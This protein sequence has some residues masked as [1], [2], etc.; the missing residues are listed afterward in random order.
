MSAGK[1]W[2]V[3]PG[4]VRC[5]RGL[6]RF[7]PPRLVRR[8]VV[9]GVVLGTAVGLAPAPAA[10]GLPSIEKVELGPDRA[11]HLNGQPFFPIMAWLQDAANFAA[12]RDCGMNTTAGYWP[13]SSG[14]KDVVEY[15]GLVAKAGLYGVMPF[16]AGLK[17]HPQLLGYIHDDEPDLP[18]QVS[19]ADVLPVSPLALNRSTPLWK[20]VDGVTHSWSVLDPLEKAT[21]AI[22]LR[23]P[24]T[25]ERLAVWLTISPGLAVAKELVFEGDGKPL[26]TAVLDA[27]KG[28]QEVPLPTPATFSELKLVVKSTYPGQ[29][30]WGSIG[31]IEGFDKAGRNVLLAP[32]RYEPRA[33]PEA[34]LATYRQIKAADAERP[35]FM[36][37]TGHFH[38][39]FTQ[40]TNEQRDALYPA[41]IQGA[42]VVGYDI[43]P[44]YGWNKP[45]WLHLVHDATEL[46]ARQAAPRPV[47]AWI[48]TSK[49]GQWT[50]P[51]EKQ[52]DVTPAHIRAEV[53]MAICRG[54]TAIGYFTHVWKPSY[55]QFGVPEANRAA[56]REI[57][58]QLTRL[59]PAILSGEPPSTVSIRAENDVK[60]EILA[61][62]YAGRL[63]LFAVNYDER[64]VPASVTMALAGLA[65]GTE[66]EVIDEGRVVRAEAGCIQ[67][68]FAP[69]AVHL[70]RTP[71]AN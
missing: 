31:E 26:T 18:H 35:V 30:A 19:D 45:E 37:L 52:K 67:D 66:V 53:W 68:S 28:S 43:Y 41:Y 8:A 62:R 27:R 13:G 49:G 2:D 29:N 60:V 58:G 33:K 9:A 63:Y 65:A 7:R 70:Y 55:Q 54:A 48:E 39:H 34:V 57:N 32:P 36:T 4:V 24:V 46:L 22:R 51:L 6:A 38:P 69:L 25:I 47:Y 12:V 5:S 11:F 56:L 1:D 15:H 40:W 42:D 44:I 21:L 50:G 64:A 14:T 3:L 71:A 20:L 23:E 59:A 17:G 10:E 16:H 61:R